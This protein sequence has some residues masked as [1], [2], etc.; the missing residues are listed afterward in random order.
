MEYESTQAYIDLVE[1]SIIL[2]PGSSLPMAY[3]KQFCPEMAE[4]FGYVVTTGTLTQKTVEINFSDCSKYLEMPIR[5]TDIYNRLWG[6]RPIRLNPQGYPRICGRK[7]VAFVK[8]VLGGKDFFEPG[9]EQ[10]PAFVL[11]SG[12]KEVKKGFLKAVI[13]TTPKR[14]IKEKWIFGFRNPLFKEEV[15]KL[16]LEFKI[17]IETDSVFLSIEDSKISL[18]KELL[19]LQHD[20]WWQ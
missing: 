16:L 8:I 15:R 2:K 7:Y 3:P 5:I 4:L 1:G 19:S 10:I 12:N 6:N 14:L 17:P 18:L 13:G 11:R 20:S 9:N